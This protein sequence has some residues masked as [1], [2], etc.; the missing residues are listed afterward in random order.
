MQ[1]QPVYQDILEYILKSLINHPENLEVHRT[2]DEMGVLLR[3]NAHAQDMGLIVGRKGETIKSLR[4]IMR[5]IGLKHHARVNVKI[6]EPAD[7]DRQRF[8]REVPVREAP[9]R[10]RVTSDE[11]IE[12]LKQD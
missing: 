9:A 1:D 7:S 11:I 6:E 8:R 5:A 3:V 12:T 10:E 4:S 2:L